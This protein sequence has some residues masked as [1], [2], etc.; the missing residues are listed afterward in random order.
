MITSLYYFS[1]TLKNKITL[2]TFVQQ[3]KS[4]F[5]LENFSNKILFQHYDKLHIWYILAR[6][7]PPAIHFL[8]LNRTYFIA[9]ENTQRI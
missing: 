5:C 7:W 1:K 9:I 6:K 3:G 4:F 8:K 2:F